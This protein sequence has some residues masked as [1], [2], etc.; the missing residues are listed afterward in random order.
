MLVLTEKQFN[1]ARSYMWL[2]KEEFR[3]PN[4]LLLDFQSLA[5]KTAKFFNIYNDDKSVPSRLI[6]LAKDC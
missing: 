1:L 3:D 6:K 5:D 4:S 2:H